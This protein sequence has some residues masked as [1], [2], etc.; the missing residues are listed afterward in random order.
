MLY[1]GRA[2]DYTILPALNEISSTQA[3][4]TTLTRDKTDMLLNYLSTN[5]NAVLR[6]KASGM[7]LHID[8]DAAYLV[9]PNAKS[10]IAGYYFLGDGTTTSPL[11]AA[12]HIECCLLKHV[13]SSAA[14]AETGGVFHNCQ[15]GI[16][17][18]RILEILDHPQPPT[19][20]K[21][22]NS[23]AASFVNKSIKQKRS[24]SWD[25]RFHWLRDR[26]AQEQYD[27][28][29]KEGIDNNA[30]YYTKHHAPSHHLKMRPLHLQVNCMVQMIELVNHLCS[31]QN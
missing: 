28:Y 15:F 2:V 29:W 23:T 21:T 9:A 1:Y 27:I 26:S 8:T 18:R 4:P 20:V 16:Q 11:N 17:I 31:N 10:R 5:R 22:D 7:F 3:K 12:V 30:D 19:K 25:M 13:V 6:F 24:K 14:E